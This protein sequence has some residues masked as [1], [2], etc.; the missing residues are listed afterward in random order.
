MFLAFLRGIFVVCFYFETCL[1]RLSVIPSSSTSSPLAAHA[2][3]FAAGDTGSARILINASATA[4]TGTGKGCSCIR[5]P[6]AA[7]AA[8]APAQNAAAAPAPAAPNPPVKK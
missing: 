5:V 8:P 4:G 7:Q 3:A 1:T 2:L 6:P